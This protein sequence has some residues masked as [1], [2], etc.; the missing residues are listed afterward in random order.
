MS[1]L[2]ITKKKHVDCPPFSAPKV[3]LYTP[4]KTRTFMANPAQLSP[5]IRPQKVLS[6]KLTCPLKKKCLKATFLLKWH[7]SKGH[8]SFLVCK[9]QRRLSQAFFE[10][11]HSSLSQKFLV[12]PY[13]RHLHQDVK[14][15]GV[16]RILKVIRLSKHPVNTVGP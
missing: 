10:L 7:F 16:H 6:R 12:R 1:P 5:P 9:N 3:I 15:D 8:A 11:Y 13:F 14:G 2:N 4:P